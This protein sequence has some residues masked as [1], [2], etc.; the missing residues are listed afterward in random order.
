M[1]GLLF[2]WPIC[3]VRG[4]TSHSVL[5][6][7]VETYQRTFEFQLDSSNPH[8]KRSF[9]EDRIKDCRFLSVGKCIWNKY[10]GFDAFWAALFKQ[11]Y[12]QHGFN[13]WISNHTLS[14]QYIYEQAKRAPNQSFMGFKKESLG[15]LSYLD[16]LVHA[17]TDGKGKVESVREETPDLLTVKILLDMPI[18]ADPPTEIAEAFRQLQHLR[19]QQRLNGEKKIRKRSKVYLEVAQYIQNDIERHPK[20]YQLYLMDNFVL[21]KR[22]INGLLVSCQNPPPKKETVSEFLNRSEQR[23]YEG[24][25]A[26]L[27]EH[28]EIKCFAPIDLLESA[29][30][31]IGWLKNQETTISFTSLLDSH[32]DT[33]VKGKVV[34]CITLHPFQQRKTWEDAPFFSHLFEFD[35]ANLFFGHNK[36]FPY[37]F[38]D[39]CQPEAPTEFSKFCQYYDFLLINELEEKW[40]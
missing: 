14:Q 13:I 20:S 25:I 3:T 9:P 26:L 8:E 1:Y 36:G 40:E 23:F 30:Q 31:P 7:Y 11:L 22:V 33:P 17:L 32:P 28:P 10:P 39:L 6:K 15:E 29:K 12:E 4:Q 19:T 37:S 21:F 38:I 18:D 16:S 27:E 24:A 35:D 5:E 2:L 34:S